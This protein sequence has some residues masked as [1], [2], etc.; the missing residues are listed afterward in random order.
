MTAMT[1]LLREA[2]ESPDDDVP[3]LILADWLDDQG[4]ADRAEFIR[5]QVA[6]SRLEEDDPRRPALEAL[7]KDLLGRNARAWLGGMEAWPGG[8]EFRRGLLRLS[9]PAEFLA[10][11]PPAQAW[12][13]VEEVHLVDAS[14][15][16]LERLSGSPLL[17]GVSALDLA[18]CELKLS[19]A[20]VL[21]DCPWLVNLRSLQLKNNN[22]GNKG[23]AL[24]A[25]SPLLANLR[26]LG[27][28]E[29]RFGLEGALA[30]ASSRHLAGL[31]ALDLDQNSAG[32]AGLA[33]L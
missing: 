33:A 28:A 18:S 23:V 27:L 3:R 6:L 14:P 21:A 19:G 12:D 29:N 8:W 1:G 22:I 9:A 26:S 13:W 17:A 15:A 4:E 11:D 2:V 24:L 25:A 7:E 20:R 30:L 5:A 10:S 31:T 32:E 16:A